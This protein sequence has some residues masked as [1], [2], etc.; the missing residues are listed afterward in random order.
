MQRIFGSFLV[1]DF[2]LP[3]ISIQLHIPVFNLHV[4]PP[5]SHSDR[6]RHRWTRFLL[7]VRWY[8]VTQALLA[9]RVEKTFLLCISNRL[10]L[11]HLFLQQG[12]NC[13]WTTQ[14]PGL[15]WLTNPSSFLLSCWHFALELGPSNRCSSSSSS[16]T[17]TRPALT[18]QEDTSSRLGTTVDRKRWKS[19]S[20]SSTCKRCKRETGLVRHGDMAQTHAKQGCFDSS[21]TPKCSGKSSSRLSDARIVWTKLYDASRLCKSDFPSTDLIGVDMLTSHEFST[22]PWWYHEI[23]SYE[24]ICIYINSLSRAPNIASP[25]IKSWVCTD[26]RPVWGCTWEW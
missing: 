6:A 20:T 3:E 9:R 5:R 7:W 18:L 16:R 14:Q 15:V 19:A 21:G 12:M 26:T 11:W 1:F 17:L 24:L 4:S 2:I 13:F 25:N 10:E 8:L 23:T 22:P